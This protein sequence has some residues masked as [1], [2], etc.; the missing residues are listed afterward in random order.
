MII[1]ILAIK[2]IPI[3]KLYNHIYITLLFFRDSK[4]IC[5]YHSN[6]KAFVY[7]ISVHYVLSKII[8]EIYFI[9]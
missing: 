3:M 7:I 5:H 8:L 4:Q 9:Y 1:S 2:I 6:I